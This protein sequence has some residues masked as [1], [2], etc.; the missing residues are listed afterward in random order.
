M[1]LDK[2][3]ETGPTLL[4]PFDVVNVFSFATEHYFDARSAL[5]SIAGLVNNINKEHSTTDHCT[6]TN[7][8]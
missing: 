2:A 4:S 7:V 1:D 3:R 6:L 8:T 5:G